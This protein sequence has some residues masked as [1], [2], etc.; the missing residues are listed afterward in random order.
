M[1][2]YLDI[3]DNKKQAKYLIAKT[4]PVKLPKSGEKLWEIHD[5]K[6]KEFRKKLKEFDKGRGK[7][8]F[9]DFSLIDLK[10][11][12]AKRILIKCEFCERKCGVDRAKGGKGFCGLGSKSLLSSEFIHNGEE[13]SI[14]PSHTFFFMGCNFYCIYCQ[15]WTISR[16]KERGTEVR[17]KELAELAG[18]KAHLS[19]N[20]NLVGGD[21]TPNLHT[22][23][24][25]LKFMDINKP[26]VW[27]SNM[28]LSKKSMRLLEGMVDVYL[29]D[30]KY[31]NDRCAKKLSKVPDYWKTMTRNYLLAKKQAEILIRHLV[32]PNHLECCTSRILKWTGKNLDNKIRMN[33]MDQYHPEF[34]VF[35]FKGMCRRVNQGEME[36][37][38][39]LAKENGI[40]N[41]EP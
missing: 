33:I 41:L 24:E 3:T 37:A 30:F 34:E 20:I 6:M 38:F 36:R 26:I 17:G 40:S 9:A 13:A 22:I 8:K 39:E 29:A 27:N 25:M 1:G 19:R 16:Q 21:P 18:R 12:I 28:Y 35:E 32:L 7:L 23:L 31:G 2:R 10:L 11:E 14:I 5:S 4:I 15:N